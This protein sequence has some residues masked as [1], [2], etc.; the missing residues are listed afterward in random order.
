MPYIETKT[1]EVAAPSSTLKPCI[2]DEDPEQLQQLSA[3][4]HDMGYESFPPPIQNA[5]C[6]RCNPDPAA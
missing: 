2:L 6:R 4:I 1:L 5:P 3:L